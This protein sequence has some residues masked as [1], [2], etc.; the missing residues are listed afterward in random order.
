MLC[1]ERKGARVALISNEGFADI[2]EIARQD[3]PSLYDPFADRPE[4]LVRREDRLE[5]A[6]RLDANGEEI[7]AVSSRLPARTA[8]RH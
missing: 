5:V 6:G 8:R 4:P 2:I 3:R 7:E 1:L